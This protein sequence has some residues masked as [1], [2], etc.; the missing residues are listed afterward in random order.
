MVMFV[1]LTTIPTQKG[2]PESKSVP[3]AHDDTGR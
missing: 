3:A 2:S 1:L